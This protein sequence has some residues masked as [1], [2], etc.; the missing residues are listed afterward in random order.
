[1]TAPASA[2][3]LSGLRS[4]PEVLDLGL[5]S[6][7][8]APLLDPADHGHRWRVSSA[9]VV[10]CSRGKR[11]VVAYQT[12][13]PEAPGPTVIGKLYADHGRGRAVHGVVGQL[14]ALDG[15]CR[16]PQPVAYLPDVGM[17]VY[18]AAPGAPLYRVTGA[19]RVGGVV[20]AASW[21]AGL[22]TSGLQLE[23]RLDDLLP[24]GAASG[25]ARGMEPAARL[26]DRPAGR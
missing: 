25:N 18:L 14:W 3:D 19:A 5:M 20:A 8:L 10:S 16:V 23:R 1:M 9:Q 4:L 26:H 13:G 24:A 12:A 15:R 17:S 6:A 11:A 7:R 2:H 21:L 22:H